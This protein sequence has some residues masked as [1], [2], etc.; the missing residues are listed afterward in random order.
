MFLFLLVRKL[1]NKTSDDVALPAISN[2]N[3]KSPSRTTRRS[4]S[5]A[6][7]PP[8]NRSQLSLE[9][10]VDES[11]K[12]PSRIKSPSI[13]QSGRCSKC[14][15]CRRLEVTTNI[16]GSQQPDWITK[17]PGVV[18]LC[19]DMDKYDVEAVQ[20][21]I[22]SKNNHLLGSYDYE[23]YLVIEQIEGAYDP[24]KENYYT[25][26]FIAKFDPTIELAR[27]P[28]P[29]YNFLQRHEYRLNKPFSVPLFN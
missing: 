16:I 28:F 2:G 5:I 25:Q 1:S 6:P 17:D 11:A 27:T 10:F 12:Q 26:P 7:A 15:H 20:A 8:I 21:K 23:P 3:Y 29:D 22:I 13:R 18:H 19:I 4:S 9:S 24:T 14:A